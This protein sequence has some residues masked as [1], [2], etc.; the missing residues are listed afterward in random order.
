MAYVN[1]VENKLIN[2]AWELK[3][4]ECPLIPMGAVT[5]RPS[6][7]FIRQR[8]GELRKCGITQYLIYPRSGCELAYMSDEWL[9]ACETVVEEAEAL[10]FTSLWLY[11]EYN[12]PSGQCGG[13]VQAADPD[14]RLP[15]L[16]AVPDGAGGRR[17][18]IE[19]DVRYPNVLNPK[20]VEL[21]IEL[22]HERYAA[23]LGRYFGTLIKG[24]FTDEPSPGYVGRFEK[25]E[26]ARCIPCYPELEAEYERETGRALRADF[27]HPAFPETCHR[28]IGRRFRTVFF[29]RLRSWCDAHGLLLTGHLMAEFS[30]REAKCFNGDPLLAIEGFSLPGLDEIQTRT[31]AGGIEWLTFG[32]ARSG[33]ERRGNGGLAELFALGPADLPVAKLRQMIWLAALFG[34]DRYVLAVN[35]L[36]FRGNIGKPDWFNPMS[37]DQPWFASAEFLAEDAGIAAGVARKRAVPELEVRYPADEYELHP[38]LEALVRAQR[39]WRLI[40][41]EA[42][43]SPEAP[44]VLAGS[45]SGIRFERRREAVSSV[46]EAVAL[47]D[48]LLPRRLSVESSAGTPAPDLLVRE[49]EDGT[50]AVLDLTD[51]PGERLLRLK[52]NGA[53]TEFVLPGRGRAVFPGWTVRRGGPNFCRPSFRNGAYRFSVGQPL[54]SVRL[55]LRKYG[56][57]VRALLDGRAIDT[58]APVPG[59]PEGFAG[60]YLGSGPLRLEAGTHLL[61]LA[62]GGDSYPYLPAAW[63]VGEFS[64]FPPDRLEPDRGDGRGLSGFA[65]EVIQSGTLEIPVDAAGFDLDCDEFVTEISFDGESLGTR[66]WPPFFWNVPERFRGRRVACRIVRRT[67]IGPIFGELGSGEAARPA[68]TRNRIPGGFPL[69]H[70]VV[71]PRFR[72]V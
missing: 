39:P 1:A 38:L 37:A 42:T 54:E 71:E 72:R 34:V 28:L 16:L 68:W 13:R 8:L 2:N 10:G 49:Y 25:E 26:G 14:F 3:M 56:E 29:D 53:V 9:D 20:A 6:R 67:S 30:V 59:L 22:T 11:D 19:H 63:L 69:R 62:D 51:A 40:A 61:E 18:R 4:M 47:L 70:P 58:A 31:T 23:R 24:I 35:Q 52:R 12:W 41:S 21:F 64:W 36:D 45:V 43:P 44:E 32:T 5:G 55:A 50:V 46:D 27:D 60:L 17:F 48:R 15:T 57:P 65:G 33:I 66:L 7:E